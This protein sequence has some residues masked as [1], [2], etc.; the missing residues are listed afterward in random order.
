MVKIK[1]LHLY[2]YDIFY[3]VKLE[4]YILTIC[5]MIKKHSHI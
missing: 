4:S 5:V 2:K 3:S 1:L